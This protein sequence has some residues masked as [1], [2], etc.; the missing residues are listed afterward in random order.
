MSELAQLHELISRCTD[1]DLHFS[2]RNAVPGEGP[3]NAKIMFV[4]EAP[5]WYEDQQGRPFVG[6]AGR[7]LD[8]LLGLAGLR[9]QDVFIAN[10]VKHRPPNNR[11]PLPKEIEACHKWLERQIEIIK[12]EAI[13]TL[14]RH[15][16]AWFSPGQTIG[17]VH[18][19]ARVQE[20]GTIVIHMYHP[21]AA[22]HQQT[23]RKTIEE[24]FKKLPSIVAAAKQEAAKR[25]RPEPQQ[26]G[27]QQMRLF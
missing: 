19:T 1:C 8:D 26:P 9:R 16:L 20:D 25:S 12:P 22:L 11:D 21:A 13:V 7:F 18:G 23:F 15:S 6:P 24:D 5:G 2:A 10:V 14:G 3:E 27:A 17:K 4:G